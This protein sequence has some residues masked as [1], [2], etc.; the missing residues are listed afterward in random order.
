MLKPVSILALDD[1]AASL[2]DAVQRR[3][4]ATSGL[5]ELVQMRAVS[6]DAQLADVI[7]SIHA[8]RQ[9]PDSA[10][11]AREDLGNR[12]L[13]LLL[14]T[15]AGP[16][17]ATAIETAAQLRRL[18][19][20]RRLAEFYTIEILCLLPGLFASTAA[21][22]GAAYS[23]LKSASVEP[24]PFD[25]FWLLDSTNANRV[26][27]GRLDESM[28]AYAEAIAGALTHEPEMSG[29]LPGHDP[30]GMDPTFSSFGYAELF[31]PRDVALQRIESRLAADLLRTQLLGGTSTIAI[32]PQ[33]AAK[34]FVVAD[35]FAVPLS[36]IGVESGQSLFKRFQPKT[37]VGEKTRDAEEVIAAVRAELRAYRESTHTANL[38]ALATQAQQTSNDL[39]ALL[40]RVGD[41]TLDHHHYAAAAQLLEALLDPMPDI[42][43]DAHVAPR[44]LV[45]EIQTATAALDQGVRFT[46]NTTASADARKRVRELDTLLQD[47]QLVAETLAPADI[48]DELDGE[49]VEQRLEA[50]RARE[51]QF[52]AMKRE[53]SELTLR[54]PQLLFAEERENNVARNAARDAEAARLA[55]QT[56]TNEQQMRD[57]FAEK[58]RAEQTLRETLEERR[59]YISR[60]IGWCIFSVSAIYAI[61]FAL[62]GLLGV[63][64]L[65]NIYEAGVANLSRVHWTLFVGVLLFAG[66][67][68]LRYL[69]D[70]GPRL[71]AA[72]ENIER[73]RADIDTV[74]KAKNNAHNAELQFEYDVAHRRATLSA[75]RK[76]R[77]V[78]RQAL[79]AM[80]ERQRE[81]LALAATLQA[82]AEA[83][84]IHSGGLSIAVVDD[85]DLDAWYERTA[86]DRKLCFLE[87]AEACMTRSQSLHAALAEVQQRVATYAARAFDAFRQLTLAG[88]ARIAPEAALAQRLKRFGEYGGPLVE[89]RDDDLPAQQAMQR[90]STLWI[91]AGDRAFLSLVQRRLPDAHVKPATDAL[92]VHA[93]TRVLHYPAYALA[94]IDY[95]RAH[96]DAAHFATSANLPDLLPTELVLNGP[97]RTAYEQI[98]LARALGIIQVR[99]DG[100]LARASS[101][102]VLGDTH[103]AAAQRLASADAATFREE[104]EGELAPR[105]AVRDDVQRDLREL[106]K[107]VPPLSQFDRSM[108]GTLLKRLELA[109]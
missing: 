15:A 78:A 47:Q 19:D 84:S 28:Q 100:Q 26:K 72:L 83:A 65:R 9:S 66:Y 4:A 56:A 39:S 61:P 6:S 49:G 50:A 2:A 68:Y 51:A 88:A 54:L 40:A 23:L 44:N 57:L 75:L 34:Q 12:E 101:N 91:D 81:L 45:T 38:H 77:E 93:L 97:L 58:P 69:G 42:R 107:V 35:A 5:D 10:L 27:F 30:R 24:Q 106:L 79:D 53:K 87:F 103:L 7:E 102:V 20:M 76:L 92:H 109:F 82:R 105:L 43:A 55:E 32:H 17:N 86:A 99:N 98:L 1:A 8:R 3:V 63:P 62:G 48:V 21:D 96:Y 104:L 41:E 70:I 29:A 37:L 89:V 46:P 18:Y 22:Y 73:I 80:R 14:V 74:D 85:A 13:V 33:L 31:F 94:Q 60:Q 11:R 25:A 52:A 67:A 95:Y 108:V 71:R 36:R 90:D 16:A 59:A 64:L